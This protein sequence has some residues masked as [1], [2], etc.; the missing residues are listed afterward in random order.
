[1]SSAVRP[2]RQPS[3]A[4]VQA[5]RAALLDA[6]RPSYRVPP[7]AASFGSAMQAVASAVASAA[8]TTAAAAAQPSPPPPSAAVASVGPR[9]PPPSSAA[10]GAMTV[11][12]LKEELRSRRLR[13]G[14]KK[15]ELIGRLE[16]ATAAEAA[17][18]AEATAAAATPASTPTAAVPATPAAPAAAA[19]AAAAAADASAALDA[20]F[21]LLER[22]MAELPA[23]EIEHT[24]VHH[25][26]LLRANTPTPTPTPKPCPSS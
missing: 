3:H 20:G 7:D 19:A 26:V 6:M 12:Q 4:T 10:W 21:R 24:F 14:G 18:A 17:E 11:A 2:R 15:A 9:V 5:N 22:A 8:A 1:M 13:L 23:T 16:D 25:Q